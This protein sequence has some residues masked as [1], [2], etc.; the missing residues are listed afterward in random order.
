MCFNAGSG[1]NNGAWHSLCGIG[2]SPLTYLETADAA[3]Y[4]DGLQRTFSSGSTHCEGPRVGKCYYG[5]FK[6]LV[7]DVLIFDR[8]LRPAEIAELADPYNIDLRV[9]NVPLLLPE[10][11]RLLPVGVASVAASVTRMPWH[12]L[13]QGVD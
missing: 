8:P 11:P 7:A 3:I 1:L 6:G 12:L 5:L 2:F 9:G 13:V 10:H 4:I